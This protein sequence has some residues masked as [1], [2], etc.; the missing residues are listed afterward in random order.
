MRDHKYM[1]L[2]AFFTFQNRH[3]RSK[4]KTEDNATA[5]YLTAY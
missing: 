5:I 2:C 4:R 3:T 1:E